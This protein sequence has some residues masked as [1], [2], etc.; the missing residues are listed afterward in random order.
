MCCFAPA[1]HK[2]YRLAQILITSQN[3]QTRK[4]HRAFFTHKLLLLF[5]GL[6]E[7]AVSPLTTMGKEPR[8][9]FSGAYRRA[10]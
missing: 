7:R 2:K 8:L 3:G 6:H 1:T 5:A 4:N 9:T 10:T